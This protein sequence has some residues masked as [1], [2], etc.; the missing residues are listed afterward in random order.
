MLSG[1]IWEMGRAQPT[2]TCTWDG[3]QLTHTLH[4]RTHIV[5][6][7][8]L[9]KIGARSLFYNYIIHVCVNVLFQPT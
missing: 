8:A 4:V 9:I 5:Y 3:A 6:I 1:T 7:E 2:N